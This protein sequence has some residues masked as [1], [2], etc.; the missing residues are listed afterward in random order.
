MM[1]FGLIFFIICGGLLHAQDI[2]Y[3]ASLQKL[4][5]GSCNKTSIDPLVWKTI[6]DQDPDA[7]LWLGDIVYGSANELEDLEARYNKQKA[8]PDY[9]ILKQKAHVFGIWDD[10]DYGPNDGGSG[11][12]YKDES[13]ALLL[14]FLE[15][16]EQ[17]PVRQRA[18][19][20]QAYTFGQGTQKVLLIL[21]DNR[22]FKEPYVPDTTSEQRYLPNQG[23]LLGPDQWEWLNDLLSK[24]DAEVHLIGTGIQF[25][26]DQHPYEKWSNFP[27]AKQTLLN[28]LDT[29]QVKNPIF[30][31][32]DRHIAELS[33]S[34]TPADKI[35]YD[36]TSSGITHSYDV[37]QEEFN[38]HR[39]SP[40][41]VKRNFGI[42]RFDWPQR[43]LYLELLGARGSRLY[44]HTI[45]LE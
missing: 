19:V 36:F 15:L 2:N 17:H 16:E 23:S 6:A 30:L 8:N 37:L 14:Q 24:S 33:A 3:Q 39:I 13:K 1:R 12:A 18:G 38:P 4:A 31:S 10:H 21:L 34:K 9:Q 25:L 22:Y 7:W 11:Y 40:L 41:V 42:L 43:Q 44:S 45:Y 20:Y 32:G 5:F 28:L 35:I 26:S 29:H 27:Q